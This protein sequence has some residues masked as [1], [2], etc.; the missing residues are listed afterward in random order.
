MEKFPGFKGR[1]ERFRLGGH[2]RFLIAS[3]SD[4]IFAFEK[5][6]RKPLQRVWQRTAR[7][8]QPRDAAEPD[9]DAGAGKVTV[10][11]ERSS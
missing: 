9:V 6:V 4:R 2:I 3:I 7:P 10:S 5:C 11:M 1:E 8:G